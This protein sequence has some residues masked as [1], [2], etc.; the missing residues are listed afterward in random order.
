MV[1]ERIYA[2]FETIKISYK[3]TN[4]KIIKKHKIRSIH[5]PIYKITIH[6]STDWPQP[7]TPQQPA[8]KTSRTQNQTKPTIDHTRDRD[9]SEPIRSKPTRR[10]RTLAW[11][12]PQNTVE[13]IRDVHLEQ[14][15][16]VGIV[17][18]AFPSHRIALD[19]SGAPAALMQ[20]R[21]ATP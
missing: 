16:L 20:R 9:E 19:C 21:S 14:I 17:V 4:N 18:E 15:L 8:T 12:G 5:W 7:T 11:V 3:N 2:T 10:N 1:F 13:A 6:R